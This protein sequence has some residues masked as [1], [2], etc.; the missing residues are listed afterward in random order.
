MKKSNLMKIPEANV[1]HLSD[2][3]Y[4]L[5]LLA[6]VELFFF[7]VVWQTIYD[8][9]Q[10]Q[11]K[12]KDR[13]YILLPPQSAVLPRSNAG[14]N[15]VEPAPCFVIQNCQIHNFLRCPMCGTC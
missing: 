12:N 6:P 2:S 9:G 10:I 15:G 8:P 7:F 3:H 5:A 13:G 11:Q 1:T 14:S 4:H